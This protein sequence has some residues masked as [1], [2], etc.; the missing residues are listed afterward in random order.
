MRF[1]RGD[2]SEKDGHTMKE[3]KAIFCIL[4]SM[5][6]AG[7][8]AAQTYPG[9]YPQTTLSNGALNATIYL[10]DADKGFYRGTRF[11]WAGVIGSLEYKGHNYYGP[12]FEKF[13]PSVRDVVIGD[14]IEAGVNSAASG[15]VEEFI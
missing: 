9:P 13:D 8:I 10:P 6:T 14:P 5:L 7:S 12:F 2:S 1:Q 15:P 11:D 3:L 4:G